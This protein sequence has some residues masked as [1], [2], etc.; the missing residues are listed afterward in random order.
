MQEVCDIVQIVS[1]PRRRRMAASRWDAGDLDGRPPA[2]V[3]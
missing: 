2:S 1:D 3:L